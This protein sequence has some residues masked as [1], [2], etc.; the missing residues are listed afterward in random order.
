MKKALSIYILLLGAMIVYVSG[1]SSCSLS[2]GTATNNV[3]NFDLVAT[4]T[5]SSGEVVSSVVADNTNVYAAVGNKGLYIFSSSLVHMYAFV[6]N[7]PI[8]AVAVQTVAT[9][10][11]AIVGNAIS[12]G[13]GG[14]MMINVTDLTNIQLTNYSE[15]ANMNPNSIVVDDVATNIFTADNL[16]GYQN[17]TNSWQTLLNQSSY[18]INL[19]S[20]GVDIALGGIYIYVAHKTGGVSVINWQNNTVV[21]QITTTLWS[22]NAVAVDSSIIAVGDDHGLV[23]YS[24]TGS[25]SPATPRYIASYNCGPVYDIA[26]NGNDFFLA[27]GSAGVQKVSRTT[28][29]TFT[30]LKQY[31]D[32][33]SYYRL[34]YNT[35]TYNLYAACGKDGIRI[36]K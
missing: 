28:P 29:T 36:L 21:A 12:S 5:G 31:N 27:L 26:F 35:F 32:G 17:Y 11:Y 14:I 20:P 25:D 18:S 22:A 3:T 6:S 24:I 30:L 33:A 8:Q 4:W 15:Y 13:K 9:K 1:L 19:N 7:N 23:L 2:N 10:K 34:S 16:K